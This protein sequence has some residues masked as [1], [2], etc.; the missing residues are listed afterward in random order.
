MQP[1]LPLVNLEGQ[2]AI[3]WLELK[4]GNAPSDAMVNP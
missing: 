4:F 1:R 2:A 3:L